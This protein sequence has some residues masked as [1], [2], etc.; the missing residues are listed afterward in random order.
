MSDSPLKVW[1]DRDGTL[2]RL[3]LAQPKANIVD[4]A[5]ITA[6]DS[7]LVEYQDAT[8]L[9][10]VLLDHE[11]PHFSFGASVEEHLPG[12]CNDM[13]KALHALVRTMLNFPLP[14]LVAIKGQCL[15]GGLEVAAAGSM[16]FAATD[17]KLGQPE[18]KLAVFAPAASCLL[19]E[20]I[21]QAKAEDLLL[22]GRSMGAEEALAS[23]LVDSVNEDPEADALAYFDKHLASSS[24]SSLRFAV[25]A[26]REEYRQRVIAKLERVEALYLSQL[27]KTHDA[28]EGL[29]AFLEKRPAKWEHC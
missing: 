6:L 2:L 10:A 19:P 3:R 22:S 12:S 17:A 18:I 25:L 16:L 21:G 23:G 5:M 28:V 8:A 13:L 1:L 29:T 11:G 24:A 20:R 27:M 4:A 9:R 26:A 15:G 14:L 7:A